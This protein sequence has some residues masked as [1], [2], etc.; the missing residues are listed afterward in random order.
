MKSL[1]GFVYLFTI[2]TTC[3]PV[4][5]NIVAVTHQSFSNAS[6]QTYDVKNFPSI[7][8][9]NLMNLLL[10]FDTVHI[11]NHAHQPGCSRRQMER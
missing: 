11:T 8:N 9:K 7:T 5:D 3:A 6:W 4:I 2:L 10:V 1:M